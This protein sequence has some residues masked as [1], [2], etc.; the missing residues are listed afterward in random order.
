MGVVELVGGIVQTV[1]QPADVPGRDH[2]VAVVAEVVL[3]HVDERLAGLAH[4]TTADA[5]DRG[6]E[7]RYDVLHAISGVE[8]SLCDQTQFV[9]IGRGKFLAR[10]PLE[11][12]GAA[13]RHFNGHDERLLPSKSRGPHRP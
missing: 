13:V 1:T 2:Q 7:D 10:E 8:V 9:R 4:H 6:S 11:E 5:G 12:F 3:R